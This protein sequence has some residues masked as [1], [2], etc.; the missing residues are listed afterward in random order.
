MAA[1]KSDSKRVEHNPSAELGLT[2]PIRDRKKLGDE[3]FSVTPPREDVR[4]P[5]DQEPEVVSCAACEAELDPVHSYRIDADE[6]AYHFCGD[7]CYRQWR[8]RAEHGRP[9]PAGADADADD[10]AKPG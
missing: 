2:D 3:K 5:S 8:A 10:R 7:D 1:D 6:Y 4:A 9:S